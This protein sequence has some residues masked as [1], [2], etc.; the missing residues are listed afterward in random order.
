MDAITPGSATLPDFRALFEAT[1][2][3]YLVPDAQLTIVAVDDGPLMNIPPPS[4]NASLSRTIQF[5]RT[6]D[7]E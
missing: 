5:C 7:P 3:L 4:L 6:G 1:P 2:A